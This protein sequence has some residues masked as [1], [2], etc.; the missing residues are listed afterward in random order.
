[1]AVSPS[2]RP[3][4]NGVVEGIRSHADTHL[5]TPPQEKLAMSL[6]VIAKYLII[7]AFLASANPSKT[8]ILMLATAEDEFL[9]SKR[10]K[11]KGGGTRKTPTK[12]ADANRKEK[13]PQRL[14][15]PKPFPIERLL[16]VCECILP[17]ELRYLAH[18][19]DILHQVATLT[20]LRFLT[21]TSMGA[22]SSGLSGA[23]SGGS[24]SAFDRLDNIKLK[25]NNL[26]LEL[27]ETL[28]RSV[29][30]KVAER[31]WEAL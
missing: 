25:C 18:G 9:A 24:F 21:K 20:S 6:P 14:L 28:G 26:E 4:D 23:A 16:A 30:F 3:T 22:T 29:G 27:V 7:A 13:L 31:L 17:V 8:D 11:K 12:R 19:P 2:K 1:M 10:R 5:Q 15:G